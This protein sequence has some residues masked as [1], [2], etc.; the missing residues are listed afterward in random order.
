[1]TSHLERGI[2]TPQ[3]EKYMYNILRPRDKV[4]MTLEEDA[5]KNS[6]PIVGPLVGNLLSMIANAAKAK[7]IL[8][9]GTATG[10][11]GIWLANVARKNGGKLI[12]IE[13]DVARAK[14]AQKSFTDAG[15]KDTVEIVQGDAKTEV[16]RIAR[17]S[18]EKFDVAFVDVGDKTLYTDL[19]EPCV[20]AIRRGGFLI[21]DNTLW[22][23][24][25]AD[26]SNKDRDTKVLRE[27]NT[28]V[29]ADKRLLPIIAPLRDGVTIA[30]K[31][32]N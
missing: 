32:E 22:S 25:V 21:A 8:E 13:S 9:V 16:P 20:K 3:V 7:M 15:L 14:I 5:E 12:T 19:L 28:R 29:Y 11:S 6:V 30:F 24:L 4:L 17:T 18:P 26:S 23:G 10:Y 27:F 1:M 2:V 31:L